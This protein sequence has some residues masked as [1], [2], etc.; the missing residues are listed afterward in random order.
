MTTILAFDT[1]TTSATCALVRDGVLLGERLAEAKSVL[2]AADELVRA[3]GIAPEAIDALVVG[4]GP[5]SFTSIRIG[6]ATARGLALALG[7]PAA[8]VSTLQAFGGGL[9][10]IDARRGEVFTDGPAVAS[11]S[12]LDVAG[13]LLV[14]DG[15][16]RYRE[17]FEAAGA[18]IPPDRRPRAPS[19]RAPPGRARRLLRR[20]RRD[21]AALPPRPRREAEP[22]TAVA[23]EI[24]RLGLGDLN[25][26]D[27]I[28]Q[29]AYRT[30]WSRSMFASELG[31]SSS[32][33]L[34]AF[35]GDR[36]IGYVVNSRYV[37]AW[38]VMNVAVDPDY[39]RRGIATRLLQ[40]LF[41]RPATTSAAATR[42]R[43]ASRTGTRSSSTRS[44]ASS[45]TASA[46]AT[47]RTTA[48]TR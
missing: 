1:A 48:R 41:E 31:K 10:V 40:H 9:P 34:G 8:G 32:I 44:S 37:D 18:E 15:A 7:V 43:C 39:R 6:L 16:L 3:A 45:A 20:R 46:A 11:P 28:E 38:H 24:R 2:A 19:R 27:P 21:R 17:L 12:E 36:L 30:P 13:R 22:V 25:A 29:R 23:I 4:T 5:G 26:I 47:T 35:E 33:C 14:G 42:S